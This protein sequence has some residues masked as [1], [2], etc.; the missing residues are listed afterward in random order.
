V[1]VWGILVLEVGAALLLVIWA[2]RGI[3]M[4]RLESIPNPLFTP[5]LLFAGLVATQ[6]LLRHTAYWY[7]TW[8]MALLWA[9]YGVLTFLVVQSFRRT[10]WLERLGIF[11]TVFGFFVAVFTVAQQF[12]GNGKIFW[13]IPN[14]SGW[15]FYGPYLDHSHYAG[16]MEMLV[17]IPLVFAMSRLFRNP[18]RILFGFA[19]LIMGSTIF[20]SRSLGG[21]VA[22]AAELVVLAILLAGRRRA[23]QQLALLGLLCVLLGLWVVTLQPSGLGGRLA[24]LQDPLGKAGAGYRLMIVKDSLKMIGE[25]PVL[26]WGLG[27]F[28]TVYPSFRTF[29][30]NLLVNEAHNDFVQLAVETGMFGCAVMVFFIALL[31]RTGLRRIEHWRRDPRASMALAALVGCTGLLVHSLSDFNLQ[32]PANAAL[33]FTLA[34]VATSLRFS[35]TVVGKA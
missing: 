17:P 18:M 23:S 25:R 29:Y 14:Q 35:S 12:A 13:L 33:F 31:Y 21:V 22:F 1:Q 8:Q 15:P 10:A 2:A 30:T 5:I 32:I 26:G 11:F 28:Q 4:G 16:L 34:A 20:L 19:A 6:L 27:T 24:L 3:A 7:A 9:A